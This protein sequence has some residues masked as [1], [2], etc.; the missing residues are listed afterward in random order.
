MNA[1]SRRE[2]LRGSTA[3]AAT[4][5][6]PSQLFSIFNIHS[7]QNN[8]FDAIIIGGSYSGLAAGMALG[9]SLRN[10][11]I[12]DG[13]QPCNRQTPYSH[14]FLTQDGKSPKEI[15]DL[16]RQ[17]VERYETIRFL[18]DLVTRG[19][20]TTDGIEIGTASGKTFHAKKLIIATGIRDLL[21]QIAGLSECWGISVLHCPYCHGYEVR[22]KA[23]GI[24]ANGDEGFEFAQLISHWTDD[25]TVFTNGKAL[26][27]PDQLSAL[28][29]HRIRIVETPIEK[30]EH[31]EGHLQCIRFTDGTNI[32]LKALYAR[33][34][35]E[36]QIDLHK[37][38]NYEL[39]DDGYIRVDAF[40]K[41]TVPHVFACGDNTTR[42]RTVS[43]AVATGAL[44]GMMVNR[45]LIFEEF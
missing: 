14:N 9:R 41:T 43:N 4:L 24:L 21:P 6:L 27:N 3:A 23:T 15:S 33:V 11:L 32:P 16:A 45:E 28:E 42:M 31:T 29:K 22:N 18:S 37:T 19:I 13:G 10:V 35:F 7:M 2:F 17:Q 34:S 36:Q 26:F 39:T 1:F 5:L 12:I 40:Q 20:Q 8:S 38:L 25:L 30:L 44:A